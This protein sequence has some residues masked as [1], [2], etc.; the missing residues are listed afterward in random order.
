MATTADSAVEGLID[1]LRTAVRLGDTE[2]IAARVK[3]DLIDRIASGGLHLPERYRRPLPEAYAR[4]L[5]YRDAETGFTAVVMAWGPGQRTPLHDH[6]GIWCVEGVCEGQL[7][8]TRYEL[9]DEL[10][11]GTCRFAERERLSAGVGSAGALIPP[12]EYHV[13]AN[14]T[15]RVTLTLHVYGGEMDHCGVFEPQPDGRWRRAERA[16]AYHD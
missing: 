6:A 11:D 10:G 7:E 4:R 13:L 8:V 9:L 2:A 14:P 3:Q 16:L 15:D 1:D 5:L 12:L